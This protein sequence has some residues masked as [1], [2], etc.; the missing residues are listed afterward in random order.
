M[1]NPWL[2]SRRVRRDYSRKS[3]SNPLFSAPRGG[4]GRRWR[5]WLTLGAAAAALGGWVWFAAFSPEFRI[6]DIRIEGA[7]N[8][9]EWDIRDTV[10]ETLAKRRWFVLPQ[11]SL[12]VVP[13]SAI[14]SAL[15]DRYVLESLEVTK[16]PP[17]T[18]TIRLKER[19]SA[20]LLQMPDGSQAL[21]GLDGT[22]TRL[23][24]ANEALDA[25]PKLGPNKDETA[26][27]AKPPA[28]AVLYDDR[29][30]T[31]NLRDAA[32]RPETAK[33][34]IELPK[35]FSAVFGNAPTL[36]QV[37]LDGTQAQT[38]RAITSEGWAIYLNASD[39]LKKQLDDAQAILKTKIG[40]DRKN[41]EY[42][43]VRF[44]EKVFFKLRS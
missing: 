39:D 36:N 32:V 42:I 3:F 35:A 21:I 33:A 18:L 14:V 26:A 44:G 4:G 29:A 16:V 23:Y 31:L 7:Q 38:L 43:D 13:E 15:N 27:S 25:V 20:V 34:A 9:A 22:V 8:L 28:Y 1:P 5:R 17:H 11:T 6:T 2:K 40:G 37:H 41:L 12:L 30:E 10:N 19:V 24:A